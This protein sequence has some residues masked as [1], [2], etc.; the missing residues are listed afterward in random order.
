MRPIEFKCFDKINKKFINNFSIE[1]D[2]TIFKINMFETYEIIKY[3]ELLQFTGLTDKNGVKIF[4]G[5]ILHNGDPKILYKVVWY[6]AGFM[7]KQIGARA[8]YIGLEHWRDSIEVIG[9]IYENENLI[10]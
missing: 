7:G 10:K 5:D 1:P 8:S 9:N 2:G 3:C 6:D 4:E